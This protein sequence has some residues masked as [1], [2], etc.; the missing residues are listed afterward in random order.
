VALPTEEEPFERK[1][2]IKCL[3]GDYLALCV[4][5]AEILAIISVLLPVRRSGRVALLQYGNG[6]TGQQ[7]ASCAL[8][9]Y[10]GGVRMKSRWAMF[11][12]KACVFGNGKPPQGMV[13]DA[14]HYPFGGVLGTAT[15]L[16]DLILG[17]KSYVFVIGTVKGRLDDPLSFCKIQGLDFNNSII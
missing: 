14:D 7:Y 9:I 15:P 6:L 5:M 3:S 16:E 4:V 8:W 13:G 11:Q 10:T 1:S 12:T 2:G 17:S